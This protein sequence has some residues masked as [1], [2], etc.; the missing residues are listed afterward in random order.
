MW[1]AHPARKVSSRAGRS[2]W[3]AHPARKEVHGRDAVSGTRI[4]ARELR[5][6]HGRD[7]VSGTRILRVRY[8]TATGGTP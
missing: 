5:H 3:Q 7:A 6:N 1:Q 8:V 4:P 2:E